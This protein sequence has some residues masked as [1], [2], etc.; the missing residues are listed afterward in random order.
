VP[1][2]TTTLVN[3]AIGAEAGKEILV[4][5]HAEQLASHVLYLLQDQAAYAAMSSAARSFV[6]HHYRWEDQVGKL[7]AYIQSKNVYSQL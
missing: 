6:L 7:E 4:A 2:I 1:C 5:D 3:N